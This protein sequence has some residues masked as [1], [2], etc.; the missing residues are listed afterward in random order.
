MTRYFDEFAA[1]TKF[2]K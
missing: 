1:V 2:A